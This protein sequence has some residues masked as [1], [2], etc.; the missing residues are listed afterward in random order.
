[1]RE[2]LLW[3]PVLL[4]AGW[5][6]TASALEGC[7]HGVD[8]VFAV[9]TS[10]SLTKENFELQMDFVLEMASMFKV[11]PEDTQ[12]GLCQY[13]HSFYHVF[14]LGDYQDNLSV[15]KAIQHKHRYFRGSTRTSKAFNRLRKRYF[16]KK[17]GMRDNSIRVA[18]LLTDGMPDYPDKAI[19]KAQLLKDQGVIVITI[20]IGDEIK[21]PMLEAFATAPELAFNTTDFFELDLI[22]PHV[23]MEACKKINPELDMPACHVGADIL[24]IIDHSRSLANVEHALAMDF[25]E[26]FARNFIVSDEDFHTRVAVMHFSHTVYD[27]FCFHE[28][29]TNVELSLAIN[30][31]EIYPEGSSNIHRALKFARTKMFQ[32]NCGSRES[33]FKIAVLMTDAKANFKDMAIE[34]A[35]KLKAQGVKLVTVGLGEVDPHVLHPMSSHHHLVFNNV[36]VVNIEKITAH[37]SSGACALARNTN[38]TWSHDELKVINAHAHSK[39]HQDF[40]HAAMRK[41]K[42][43]LSENEDTH[44][45][46]F[47]NDHDHAKHGH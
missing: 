29:M 33:A 37:V 8:M 39:M 32:P 31:T 1:M 45:M 47:N 43:T 6:Q 11:G 13:A 3:L 20:G 17:H 40:D 30:H 10:R 21:R 18:I 46:H 25:V 9:D 16:T 36:H 14:Y 28:F 5:M 38:H 42:Y 27:N 7:E 44:F 12:I 35:N 22:R 19:E 4:L 15:M 24:F 23:A 2:T 26:H 41:K 34:E